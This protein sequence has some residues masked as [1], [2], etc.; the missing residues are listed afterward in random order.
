MRILTF[1]LLLAGGLAALTWSFAPQ[2]LTAVASEPVQVPSVAS[3]APGELRIGV[4]HA[5]RMDSKAL[6]AYR[7]GGLE[8]RAFGMD[9]VVV[10]HPAGTLLFDAGFG[11]RVSEHA[12]TIPWLMRSLSRITPEMPVI[13]Q[14]RD[15]GVPLSQLKGVVLTHAHWDHV[16]GLDDLRGVP[17]WINQD[18]LDFVRSGHPAARL[19]R[20][21]ALSYEVY[22]F[23]GG[24]YAGFSA[25]HDVFGDGSVVLVPAGGHTPGSIVAFIHL[26]GGPSYALVGD[27]A[28]QHEGVDRPAERPWLSRMLVDDDA[29]GV[30]SA[31]VQLHALQQ[32]MPDLVV[33]PA[34]DRRVMDTLPA[35]PRRTVAE[36]G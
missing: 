5:G 33:V 35:W 25:S 29:G 13:E 3:P 31:L 1:L 11:R 34:H 20:E 23:E 26:P 9:V 4:M 27:L 14:L 10:E 15:A 2:T 30:R 17:V 18:E 12:Q 28:W 8:E 7:G 22:S 36:A 19:A 16:S 24:P 32:A 6:F 21:L